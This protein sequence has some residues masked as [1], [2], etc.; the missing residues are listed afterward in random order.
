MSEDHP[1]KPTD[2]LT[3]ATLD[4]YG[5]Q[6]MYFSRV[7]QLDRCIEIHQCIEMLSLIESLLSVRRYHNIHL[8]CKICSA[9]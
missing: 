8:L 2:S 7:Y 6:G 5:K 3:K 9:S 1:S 4:D